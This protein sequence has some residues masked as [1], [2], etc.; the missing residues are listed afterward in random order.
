MVCRWPDLESGRDEATGKRVYPRLW[1]GA[2]SA[3]L[4]VRSKPKKAEVMRPSPTSRR[5]GAEL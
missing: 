5:A 2:P 1:V 4:G 3:N